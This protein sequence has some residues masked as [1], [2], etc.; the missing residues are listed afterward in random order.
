MLIRE[1][2]VTL[3]RFIKGPKWCVVTELVKMCG[4]GCMFVECMV[5]VRR[6][7]YWVQFG[8]SK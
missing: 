8:V 1:A 2:I 4:C 5:V 6:K 7:Q 3:V